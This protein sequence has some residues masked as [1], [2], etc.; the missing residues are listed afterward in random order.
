MNSSPIEHIARGDFKFFVHSRKYFGGNEHVTNGKIIKHGVVIDCALGGRSESKYA[1]L[2]M[3]LWLEHDVPG[4]PYGTGIF[5][6]RVLTGASPSSPWSVTTP[7]DSMPLST[8]TRSRGTTCALFLIPLSG[9]DF[10]S[11]DL[12]TLDKC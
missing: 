8:S 11:E 12:S 6:L 1:Q 2:L 9:P 4:I 3:S 7:R 5:V 10:K